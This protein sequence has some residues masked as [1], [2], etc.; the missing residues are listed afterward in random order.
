MWLYNLNKKA[1][2]KIDYIKS[3]KRPNKDFYA[4]INNTVEQSETLVL[5]LRNYFPVQ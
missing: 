4:K 1:M 2:Q 3:G 5:N